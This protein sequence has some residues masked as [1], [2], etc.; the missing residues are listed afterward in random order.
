MKMP[1][2]PILLIGRTFDVEIDKAS[3]AILARFA[4]LRLQG[5]NVEMAK[6]F[7]FSSRLVTE[8]SIIM[9]NAEPIDYIITWQS[10]WEYGNGRGRFQSNKFDWENWFKDAHEVSLQPK[11]YE[12]IERHT[13]GEP[14][15][16]VLRRTGSDFTQ[17]NAGVRL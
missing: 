14:D 12:R 6:V 8:I 15:P 13:Q 2:D 16:C 5:W 1:D 7:V 10:G 11:K 4:S 3:P 9:G 17:A